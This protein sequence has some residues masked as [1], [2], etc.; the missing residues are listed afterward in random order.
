MSKSFTLA[1]IKIKAA[2]FRD[3]FDHKNQGA[4]Y[5]AGLED[6]DYLEFIKKYPSG[7]RAVHHR[8]LDDG[9]LKHFYMVFVQDCWDPPIVII[10]ADNEMDAEETWASEFDWAD[11]EE[12]DLKDYAKGN[13]N[14]GE[15]VQYESLMW[16]ERGTYYDTQLVCVRELKLVG[17]EVE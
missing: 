9:Y 4:V 10:R 17:V 2:L 12:P 5:V 1:E 7:K 16:S 15:E 11:V 13:P 8:G 6:M 14:A 3:I